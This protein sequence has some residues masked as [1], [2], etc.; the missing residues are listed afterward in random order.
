MPSSIAPRQSAPKLLHLQILRALAAS[1][2]VVDHT[3]NELYQRGALLSPNIDSAYLQGHLGVSAFFVL[4]GFIM[5]RQSADKFGSPAN[6]LTF[7]WHRILRI[8]P[9]YWIATA[10]GLAAVLV[11]HTRILRPAF[12]LVL[13]LLF[14]PNLGNPGKPLPI[15]PQGWTLNFEMAFYLLFAICLLFNRRRG[16]I[17]L[18][19]TLGILVLL[20]DLF[21]VTPLHR[22]R[23]I[24]HIYTHWRVLLFAAGVALGM[25]EI[26][27][28]GITRWKQSVSPAWLLLLPAALLLLPQSPFP[29]AGTTLKVVSLYGAIVVVLCTLVGLERPGWFN[30]FCILLG[31]ASYSTYLFHMWAFTFTM[32]PILDFYARSHRAPQSTLQFLVPAIVAANLIGLGVHVFVERPITRY[33]RRLTFSRKVRPAIAPV[34]PA[35]PIGTL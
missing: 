20:G 21:D 18:I 27:L 1:L 4:S 26:K 34:L 25:V 33:L 17:L 35:G 8:V 11:T 32:V 12:Q 30:R 14:L 9:L 10:L 28:G 16:V 13:S 6:A 19:S 2:V 7:A 3:Y 5:M 15:L 29:N 23:D 22:L 31:D 24:W